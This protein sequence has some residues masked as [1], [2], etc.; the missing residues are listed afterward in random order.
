MNLPEIKPV[1]DV[2]ER[3]I[4][5]FELQT[6]MQKFNHQ[7]RNNIV[8]PYSNNI[9]DRIMAAIYFWNATTV[10]YFEM[11]ETALVQCK[12]NKDL[13]HGAVTEELVDMLHFILN[14][15]LYI[16]FTGKEFYT[17]NAI[18][19]IYKN[20]P[21][22]N[23]KG[24][25]ND[26]FANMA[27]T[28]GKLMETMPYKIWKSYPYDE[29]RLV[30]TKQQVELGNSMLAYFIGM[31]SLLKV[32]EKALYLGYINKNIENF[33]RQMPGGKYEN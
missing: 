31:C 26:F 14:Q 22:G 27:I 7:K 21:A 16:G 20:I 30:H 5:L 33:K 12:S 25:V 8:D 2:N 4:H 6:T 9:Q 18:F 29:I 32:N 13:P 24:Y 15:L 11:V 23:I 3:L 17:L 19:E 28:W 10:E 1:K